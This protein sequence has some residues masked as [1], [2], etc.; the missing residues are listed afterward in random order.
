MLRSSKL[1]QNLMPP[2]ALIQQDIGFAFVSK[3]PSASSCILYS[4]LGSAKQ[5]EPSQDASPFTPQ[6]TIKHGLRN[7]RAEATIPQDHASKE[8]TQIT[9][10]EHCA[11]ATRCYNRADLEAF[12]ACYHPDVRVFNG[13][14]QTVSG[15][16]EFRKRY[17][18]LFTA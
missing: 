11:A 4:S 17:Q 8:G 18:S 7:R 16:D 15:I 10:I 1:S 12:V 14:E 3:L 6:E 9:Q 5:D 13:D 2:L